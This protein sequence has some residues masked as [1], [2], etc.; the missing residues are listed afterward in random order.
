MPE[1]AT[2]SLPKQHCEHDEKHSTR[3][4]FVVSRKTNG[5]RWLYVRDRSL[6]CGFPVNS[7]GLGSV[8]DFNTNFLGGPALEIDLCPD[9]TR[10]AMSVSPT[11][12]GGGQAYGVEFSA[13]SK[14]LY[15]SG[16][17]S[18]QGTTG[19]GIFAFTLINSQFAFL[20]ASN[21]QGL[22]QTAHELE[23][24]GEIYGCNTSGGL[25][26]LA[27]GTYLASLSNGTETYRQRLLVLP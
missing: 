16:N 14:T 19:A 7:S 13:D 24:D 3:V 6:I 12:S 9:G 8:V 25:V 27:S 20:S 15:I 5:V 22:N 17:Y 1:T 26:G 10:T 18:A 23:F 4:V 11:L 2:I 21:L